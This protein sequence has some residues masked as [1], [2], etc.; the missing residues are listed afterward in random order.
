MEIVDYVIMKKN[1]KSEY[2]T[3]I[4]NYANAIYDNNHRRNR[5]RPPIETTLA[6]K[7]INVNIHPGVADVAQ[8]MTVSPKARVAAAAAQTQQPKAAPKPNAPVISSKKVK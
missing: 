8:S 5:R 2:H 4:F 7:G 1:Q 3:S 6:P